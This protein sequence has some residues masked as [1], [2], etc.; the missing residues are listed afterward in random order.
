MLQ[1]VQEKELIMAMAKQQGVFAF[2]HDKIQQACY[3]LL[4]ES[5]EKRNMELRIGLQLLQ[6]FRSP[7]SQRWMLFAGVNNLNR[8]SGMLTANQK[9]ELARLNL[10]SSKRARCE[11][12][13][14]LAAEYLR[15]G[16]SLL[17]DGTK[18]TTQYKLSLEMHTLSGEMEY[19]GGNCKGAQALASELIQN[20]QIREKDKI[21]MYF[22]LMRAAGDQLNIN[23]ALDT[24]ILNA[25]QGLGVTV[26]RRPSF[27]RKIWHLLKTKKLL[28]GV[29]DEELLKLP[30]MMDHNKAEAMKFLRP[31]LIYS[32]VLNDKNLA[33]TI[34]MKEMR[35]SIRY[36]ACENTPAAFASY[37]MFVS[38]LGMT[39]DAFRFGELAE[40]L[41]D[42]DTEGKFTCCKA[43]VLSLVHSFC[44]HWRKPLVHSLDVMLDAHRSGMMESGDIEWACLSFTVYTAIY[45]HVGLPLEPF[46][47]DAKKFIQVMRDFDQYM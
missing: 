5:H 43:F 12:A 4:P 2:A 42:N 33:H 31:M 3:L 47:S 22:T 41:L 7:A 21:P 18:W 11:S 44:R 26:P 28:K 8:S 25:L 38:T 14:L 20:D 9:F 13:F 34:F 27:L 37:G 29:T 35:L 23:E 46:V 39:E 16:I 30:Q 10:E 15:K 19:A 32:A 36:G 24:G 1:L 45:T 6:F 17:D 40:H